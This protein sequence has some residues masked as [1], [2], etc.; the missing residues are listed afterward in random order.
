MRSPDLPRPAELVQELGRLSQEV[1]KALR[2]LF[3]QA[4]AY[5]N[6]QDAY[7]NLRSKLLLEAESK[8]RKEYGIERPNVDEKKA[9]VH[10]KSSRE[11]LEAD[12]AAAMKEVGIEAIRSRRAQLSALQS[13]AAAVRSELE[14]AGKGPQ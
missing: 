10:L 14:L 8:V 9:W 13:A 4:K 7:R 11:S 5:A 2:F 6:T 1:D 3:E 12:L